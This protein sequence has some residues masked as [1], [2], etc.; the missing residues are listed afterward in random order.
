M[1]IRTYLTVKINSENASDFTQQ[2]WPG[3]REGIK[4]DER[5]SEEFM[6]PSEN[7]YAFQ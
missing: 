3:L 6:I 1:H 5:K 4:T 2:K 7:P